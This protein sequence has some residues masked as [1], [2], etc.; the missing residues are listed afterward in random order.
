[1]S[2]RNSWVEDATAEVFF[3]EDEFHE[4]PNA[5]SAAT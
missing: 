4:V 2:E 3:K 1:M 5:G